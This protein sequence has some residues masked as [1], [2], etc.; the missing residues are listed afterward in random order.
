[1]LNDENNCGIPSEAHNQRGN[2]GGLYA[3]YL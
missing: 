1:M 3:V 2:R